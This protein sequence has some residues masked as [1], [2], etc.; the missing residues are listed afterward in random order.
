MN[1]HMSDTDTINRLCSDLES[2]KKQL[3]Q[4]TLSVQELKTIFETRRQSIQAAVDDL[5]NSIHILFGIASGTVPHANW[6]PHARH[7]IQ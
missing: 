2:I 1:N 6:N 3:L 7:I 5:H 4:I